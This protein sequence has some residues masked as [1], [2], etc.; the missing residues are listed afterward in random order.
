VYHH[1][2]TEEHGSDGYRT[3]VVNAAVMHD[4]NDAHA[5]V[6]NYANYTLNDMVQHGIPE[7]EQWPAA[8]S[9]AN[10]PA[11]YT[12]DSIAAP[13][14]AAPNPVHIHVDTPRPYDQFQDYH[15]NHAGQH[16]VSAP[17][18]TPNIAPVNYENMPMNDEIMPQYVGL[19]GRQVIRMPQTEA[20]RVM[21][22]A[23][24][25]EEILQGE[26]NDVIAMHGIQGNINAHDLAVV[27]I[28]EALR[29]NGSVGSRPYIVRA[30]ITRHDWN[31]A[32]NCIYTIVLDGV[33]YRGSGEDLDVQFFG[34]R[35]ALWEYWAHRPQ[36]RRA[37]LVRYMRQYGSVGFFRAIMW[38]LLSERRWIALWQ[39][40]RASR[41]G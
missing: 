14:T 21:L 4:L 33:R 41:R 1:A 16:A 31:R 32:G 13:D 8:P 10:I 17:A 30:N 12:W 5:N 7:S 37:R 26:V 6:T 11:V 27:E 3:E 29:T 40:Y 35:R 18:E 20:E 2:S 36:V 22:C 39:Q 23:S 19:D 34:L 15:A 38:H 24:F 9:A 25:R 28:S